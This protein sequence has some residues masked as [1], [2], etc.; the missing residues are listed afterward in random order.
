MS[1]SLAGGSP[2]PLYHQIAES[3]RYA[4]ATGRLKEGQY[5]T[6]VRRA[7]KDWNV[8]LH[9]VRRAYSQLASEGLVET[10][11]PQGTRV[12]ARK[13]R[14]LPGKADERRAF[15]RR[16]LREAGER[17]GI[18]SA[19]LV[20]LLAGAGEAT[21]R[22]LPLVHVVEC[23]E[24]Q[25]LGHAREIEEAWQVE[26][27]PWTVAQAEPPSGAVVATFFHYNDVRRLWPGRLAGVRFAAI[28]PDPA[29]VGELEQRERLVAGGSRARRAQK[30][31]LVL[32]ELSAAMAEN[33]AADL[34]P[35]VS[36]QRFELRTRVGEPAR[37]LAEL[38]AP[39]LALFSPRA[40]AQLAPEQRADPR[41][42]GVRYLFAP[43]ELAALGAELGWLPREATLARGVS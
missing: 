41:A 35:L 43:G 20:A 24:A 5:L 9:T 38:G 29:L 12:L 30:R 23:S 13:P 15:A 18:S 11:V 36:A 16:V 17:F 21:A 26:A 27:R 6:P 4:L 10:R 8:N 31:V 32:C 3:I 14:A 7:A 2:L 25:C 34:T 19:E 28:R 42:L 33:I 40:W 22:N 39:E 37:A 1:S